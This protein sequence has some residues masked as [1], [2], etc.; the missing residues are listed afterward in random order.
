MALIEC[1]ECGK[2]VS[3]RAKMCIHCG[4]PFEEPDNSQNVNQKGTDF[5]DIQ[6]KIK[7]SFNKATNEI[8]EKVFK[9]KNFPGKPDEKIRSFISSIAIGTG[10]TVSAIIIGFTSVFS[11]VIFKNDIMIILIVAG[12]Y[13]MLHKISKFYDTGRIYGLNYFLTGIVIFLIGFISL[14]YVQFLLGIML[15]VSVN[16]CIY[17]IIQM[18]YFLYKNL[19]KQNKGKKSYV[20][21]AVFGAQIVTLAVVVIQLVRGVQV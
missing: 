2:E 20:E 1:P 21:I 13:L 17:G 10:C 12:I 11:T 4:Y 18:G 15:L 5:S 19:I 3:D 9:E 6:D 14:L 8:N 16:L 7:D